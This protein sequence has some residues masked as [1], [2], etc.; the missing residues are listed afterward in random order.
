MAITKLAEFAADGAKNTTGLVLT[1]GFQASVKPARQWVNW[2]FNSLSVKLN[3]VIDKLDLLPDNTTAMIDLF[4]PVGTIIENNAAGFNPNTKY[5]GTTWV[6][7][8]EGL[9]SVGYSTQSGDPTWTKTVGNTFGE[10]DVLLDVNNLPDKPQKYWSWDDAS[11]TDIENLGNY[12]ANG[13][14]RTRSK[15]LT[16]GTGG[17]VNSHNNVQPSI[18]DARWRRTA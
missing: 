13:G 14:S 17:T 8:G 12:D 6:R 9:A 15:V 10:Y 18:V 2:L 4:L 5:P 16:E 7:H 1:D 11:G 3:E